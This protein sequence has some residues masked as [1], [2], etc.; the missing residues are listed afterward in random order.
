[1]ERYVSIAQHV[2]CRQR[3]DWMLID[4]HYAES[5]P[6]QGS[7]GVAFTPLFLDLNYWQAIVMLYRQSLSVPE[8]LAGELSPPTSGGVQSPS[9]STMETKEDEEIIFMKVAQAG[10][11]VLKI[12]RQL[13]RLKLVNYTFLATHHIFLCGTHPSPKLG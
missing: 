11:T 6:E 5:S 9:T 10:Q 1:V 4:T 7:T 3:L 13:H 12:Y 8:L 2:K